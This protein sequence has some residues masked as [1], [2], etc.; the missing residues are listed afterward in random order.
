MT[1]DKLRDLIIGV[2]II[3]MVFALY[4]IAYCN[5]GGEWGEIGGDGGGQYMVTIEETESG[6]C[7]SDGNIEGTGNKNGISTQYE[8]Y[9]GVGFID[10]LDAYGAK[11]TY[12]VLAK[13]NGPFVAIF[14]YAHCCTTERQ[15]LIEVNGQVVASLLPFD[16][17]DAW[18]DWSLLYVPITLNQGPNEITLKATGSGGL[19]NID[20]MTLIGNGVEP[21]D[22][23]RGD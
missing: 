15:A 2:L 11:I 4:L 3:L 9:K 23:Y 21:Q 17:P 8:G 13:D 1:Y 12:H 5:C 6:F 16:E 18:T 19:S 20:S 10:T 22:C 7:G 14:R